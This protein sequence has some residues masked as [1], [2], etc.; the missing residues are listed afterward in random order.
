MDRRFESAGDEKESE[1]PSEQSENAASGGRPSIPVAKPVPPIQRP[2]PRHSKAP[3]GRDARVGASRGQRPNYYR[4]RSMHPNTRMRLLIVA[5]GTL[6]GLGMR[7]IAPESW[8]DV[9]R[10]PM[11]KTPVDEVVRPPLRES[12]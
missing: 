10:P 12:E 9:E 1:A 3:G 8:R 7:W 6:A 4:L 5:V 2:S 11:I